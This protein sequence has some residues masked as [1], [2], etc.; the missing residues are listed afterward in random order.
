MKRNKG[1]IAVSKE[2]FTK[3]RIFYELT[4]ERVEEKIDYM[5]DMEFC[6]IWS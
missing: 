5:S 4:N 6:G 2:E 1:G 3:E